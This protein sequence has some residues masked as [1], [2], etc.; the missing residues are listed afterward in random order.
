M[1]IDEFYAIEKAVVQQDVEAA[2][3]FSW[4][5]EDHGWEPYW[6]NTV[7]LLMDGAEAIPVTFDATIREEPVGETW[8]GRFRLTLLKVEYGNLSLRDPRSRLVAHYAVKPFDKEEIRKV[9][10]LAEECGSVR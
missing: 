6:P 5:K 2:F 8:E 3:K 7:E 9:S 10:P 1:N 4:Y